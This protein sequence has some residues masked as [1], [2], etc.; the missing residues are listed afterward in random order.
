M[1]G[2]ASLARTNIEIPN[3]SSV[4]TISPTLGVIR[5]EPLEASGG[6]SCERAIY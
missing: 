2:K 5:N 1:R 6:D 4:Q 3:S